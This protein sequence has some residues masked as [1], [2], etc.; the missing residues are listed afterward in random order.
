MVG[1]PW[2]G[3]FFPNVTSYTRWQHHLP[4]NRTN[5]PLF[6]LYQSYVNEECAQDNKDEPWLCGPAAVQQTFPYIR[7]R[8][9]VAQNMFDSDQLFAHLGCPRQVC[10]QLLCIH[11]LF[12][13][14][15][16][17][18]CYTTKYYTHCC[19]IY[20]ELYTLLHLIY[21]II[22]IVAPYIRNYTHCCTLYTE[23]YTL[24]HL[25][26]GI[27]HIVAPY[28]RNY[29]H[30]CTLYTEL[31]TLLHLMYSI[32]FRYHGKCGISLWVIR[33]IPTV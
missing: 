21:G 4:S 2:A 19:T 33:Y 5:K 13:I 23:L 12:Y 7:S 8:V 6:L 11:T 29:T 16:P 1:H 18:H 24:L 15:I 25:I 10:A 3:W 32:I 22:H 30:C 27:I 9:F 31:Y 17:Y 26:Y 14:C 20:M 28:I